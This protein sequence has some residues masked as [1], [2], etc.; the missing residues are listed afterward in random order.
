MC[1][2]CMH[3]LKALFPKTFSE[4]KSLEYCVQVWPITI[5]YPLKECSWS[6]EDH[7]V[8]S[9]KRHNAW[10]FVVYL[11]DMLWKKYY[12]SVFICSLVVF[13]WLSCTGSNTSSKEHVGLVKDFQHLRTFTCKGFKRKWR[14]YLE[15]F[16]WSCCAREK[17]VIL[18]NMWVLSSW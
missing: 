6:P 17:L 10:L 2:D 18:L 1:A 9:L 14:Y 12:P 13:F 3:L 8:R 16:V 11:S 15:W 7:F 5:W 4:E